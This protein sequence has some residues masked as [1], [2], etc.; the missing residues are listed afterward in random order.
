MQGPWLVAAHTLVPVHLSV[1]GLD[2]SW[3]GLLIRRSVII[4]ISGYG[5]LLE[6]VSAPLVPSVLLLSAWG[7]YV[8]MFITSHGVSL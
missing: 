6:R 5:P 7:L 4:G 1:Y 2:P 8:Q 3:S